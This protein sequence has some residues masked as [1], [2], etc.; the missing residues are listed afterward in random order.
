MVHA[1]GL[2]TKC[3]TA[4][5]DESNYW[6]KI[7]NFIFWCSN[8]WNTLMIFF[9][10]RGDRTISRIGITH[11]KADESDFV[12]THADCQFTLIIY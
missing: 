12:Y 6:N 7:N 5:H 1:C 11:K 2:R 8:S 3:I 4:Y 10:K 9:Q